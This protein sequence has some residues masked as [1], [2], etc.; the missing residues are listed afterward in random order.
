MTTDEM[1]TSSS[2]ERPSA[3]SCSICRIT[4]LEGIAR[5]DDKD[6]SA[7]CTAVRTLRRTRAAR[8]LDQRA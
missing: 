7:R 1:I 5:D 2:S 6:P 8:R 4:I 3:R